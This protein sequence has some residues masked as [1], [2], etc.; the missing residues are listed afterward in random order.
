MEDLVE[1]RRCGELCQVDGEF[2]KF[3]AWCDTC[4]DY[5]DYDMTE[6]AA[7]YLATKIDAAHERQRDK[8]MQ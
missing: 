4:N 8:E 7:D 5:A 1:C 6:Y 3:F 2:P